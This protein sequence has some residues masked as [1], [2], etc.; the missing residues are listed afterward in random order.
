MKNCQESVSQ[1]SDHEETNVS[2]PSFILLGKKCLQCSI[3]AVHSCFEWSGLM[4]AVNNLFPVQF[5]LL[6]KKASVRSIYA[7]VSVLVNLISQQDIF[8]YISIYRVAIYHLFIECLF[9]KW[10]EI[11]YYFVIESSSI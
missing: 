10:N 4:G 6:F 1:S 11:K 3:W 9:S 5:S 8:Y 2:F 7:T